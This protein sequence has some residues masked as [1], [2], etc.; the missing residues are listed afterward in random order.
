MEAWLASVSVPTWAII[1]GTIV[2]TILL[3]LWLR[4]RVEGG[5]LFTSFTHFALLLLIGGLGY[6]SLEHLEDEARNNERN[7][8]ALRASA[9]LAQTSQNGIASCIDGSR[10]RSLHEACEKILFSE[11]Q[12]ATAALALTRQRLGF[13]SDIIA[14]PATR[15]LPMR[16]QI[17]NL[18]TA[19]EEDPFGF[20]AQTMA[21]KD[22]CT[23][24][25]CPRLNLL[26]D[27]SHVSENLKEKKFE[28]LLAKYLAGTVDASKTD[29]R[30]SM[31]NEP[32]G[33]ISLVIPTAEHSL[34]QNLANQPAAS[35]TPPKE[36]TVAPA[37][38]TSKSKQKNANA[39]AT[40][41]SP[42]RNSA[43]PQSA[44]TLPPPVPVAPANSSQVI[45]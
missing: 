26:R 37:A 4:P 13:I 33:V 5:D 1:V 23:P 28:V 40:F 41:A 39:S 29:D 27:P 42:T 9:L 22:G 21:E 7:A 38:G 32:S 36:T 2:L 35:E 15:D 31:S 20:V 12:R 3:M 30:R 18:R 24:E 8:T 44:P 45:R 25:Y 19:V 14:Y 11:P 43:A 10:N 17:E 34:I 6:F 16:E